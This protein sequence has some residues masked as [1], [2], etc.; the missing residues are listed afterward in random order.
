MEI[1]TKPHLGDIIDTLREITR[2]NVKER[3]PFADLFRIHAPKF[4]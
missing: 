2:L 1:S 3:T 4:G